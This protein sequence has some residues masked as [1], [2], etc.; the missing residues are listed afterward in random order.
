LKPKTVRVPP[1]LEP[2]FARMEEVVSDDFGALARTPEVA[3]IDCY[4]GR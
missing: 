1:E 2:L 4:P 3:T